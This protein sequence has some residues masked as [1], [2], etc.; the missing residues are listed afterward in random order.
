MNTAAAVAFLLITSAYLEFELK[1]RLIEESTRDLE[2]RA[3]LVREVLH[4]GPPGIQ[5]AAE[6][7]GTRVT[8]I[9]PS[10][11]VRADSEAVAADMDDHST[12]P[13]VRQALATGTGS[14][15][16]FSDTRNAEYLYVAVARPGD[17]SAD[18]IRVAMP[19]RQLSQRLEVV[20]DTIY[21]AVAALLA[22]GLLLSFVLARYIVRPVEI[23]RGAAGEIARGNLEVKVDLDRRDEFGE[24][25]GAFNSMGSELERR[26]GQLEANRR[27]ISTIMDNMSEGLLLVNA[28]GNIV[29]ANRAAA[30][31]LGA[32]DEPLAGRPLWESI[33]LPEVDELLNSLPKLTEPRRVWIEDRTH[34][35]R[36]VLAFVATPLFETARGEQHAV[37]L[38][39][40]ATEDQK[41]LELRQEFVANVSHELKTPLTSIS[42]YVETLLDG[43][44]ED[45]SVRGPFLLKIQSNS[46]RLTKLV[47]DIL[48]LS[49]LESGTG[50]ETRQHLDLNELARACV[51]KH[52]ESADKKGVK[53]SLHTAA[54]P[55]IALVNEEDLLEALDNLVVNAVSYTQAQGRVNVTIRRAEA[56]LLLEVADTG[57]GIPAE[58][59]P[60][61]FERFYRVDKARS[62]ALGGTGLGL[63]IVKHVAIKHGGKVEAESEV[64]KGSTFRITLPDPVP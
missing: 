21:A 17:E 24:L 50:E 37:I 62:R 64:G 30:E 54:E 25:A 55:L 28:R 31:L 23:M 12:R 8:V 59:L 20:R 18:I 9:A 16:R 36:R 57:S 40:D 52:R 29:L 13:E 3:R 15:I 26:V 61:I 32:G 49:R 7:S 33:R 46:S 27:E 22:T 2:T 47:S 34:A 48:N 56:G 43:A 41:L 45:E 6:V 19:M 5:R 51:N 44:A 53:L 42:A 60:R 11:T 10:G 39:S 4:D 14:A 35:A 58:A 1:G 63:A 38:I